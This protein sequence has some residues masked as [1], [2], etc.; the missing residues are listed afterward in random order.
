MRG[1]F[2]ADQVLGSPMELTGSIDG[3]K[4]LTVDAA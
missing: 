2:I 3:F 4:R 1:F